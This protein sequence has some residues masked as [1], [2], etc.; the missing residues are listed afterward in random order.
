M[1]DNNVSYTYALRPV[2]NDCKRWVIDVTGS[3]DSTS[4]TDPMALDEAVTQVAS[5]ARADM[6]GVE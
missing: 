4:V 6:G 5:W 3:D 2:T 1:K